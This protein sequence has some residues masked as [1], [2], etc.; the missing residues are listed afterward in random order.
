MR[1]ARKGSKAEVISNQEGA[2]ERAAVELRS[3]DK[4]GQ[5]ASRVR[6]VTGG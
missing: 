5:D 4:S 3:P 2:R 6:E 1:G